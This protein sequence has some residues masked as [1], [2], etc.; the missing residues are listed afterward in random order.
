MAVTIKEIADRMG[1]SISTISKGLN[2]AMDISEDLRQKILDTAIEM[3]Y[4]TKKMRKEG[5][6][7]LAVFVQHIK[8]SDPEDFGYD[9]ILGFKQMAGRDKWNVKVITV[10]DEMMAADKYDTYM[11]KNGFSG[12]F[13][14]GFDSEAEWIEKIP[15]T[16]IPTVLLDFYIRRNSNLALV[17]T[18]ND[19]GFE[20]SIEHLV[21]LGHKKIAFLNGP[22]GSMAA[23][24]RKLMY[25]R[26]M[27]GMGLEI[28]P[29]LYSQGTYEGDSANEVVPSF[30][31]NGATAILC[32]SDHIAYGVIDKC[33][34]LGYKVPEDISVIG[35]D[36]LPSAKNFKI[37][38]TTISQDRTELGKSAYVVLSSLVR[39]V[40][41]SK[42]LMHPRFIERS[43]TG[44]CKE[45]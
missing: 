1:V 13:F 15:T 33:L 14:M 43:T 25:E 3:G 35:F 34:E 4:Q 40:A 16:T 32:G 28:D 44:P 24:Q 6:K 45:R 41:I 10:S 31:D 22:A 17:G 21:G 26:H 42:S 23:I 36:D 18:D 11:L 30:I 9:L 12:A 2:G 39:N 19:E 37:P 27:K 8:Y 5:N 38:L 29:K 7:K 20:A